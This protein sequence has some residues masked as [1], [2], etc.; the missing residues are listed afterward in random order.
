MD[1]PG[2]PR[3]IPIAGCALDLAMIGR[4]PRE[5]SIHFEIPSAVKLGDRLLWVWTAVPLA[6]LALPSVKNAH[7]AISAQV[8]WSIWAGL[9][10]SGI[11]EWLRR[12]GW[13][14]SRLRA[15]AWTGFVSIALVY[16]TCLWL[17]APRFHRRGVEWGF[18]DSI[19]RTLP[20]TTSL[21]LLYDD[22]DRLPYQC[23]FGAVPHDLAVRLFYL[24]RPACWHQSA[25]SLRDC[26]NITWRNAKPVPQSADAVRGQSRDPSEFVV[27]GRARDL[28]VLERLGQV[29]TIARGPSVRDDRTYLVF[30]ISPKSDAALASGR[31]R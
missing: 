11:G 13:N 7:Y 3:L 12:R 19:G 23:P 18:Y 21:T 29:E 8:P 20:S 15:V 5:Q 30:R 16:G 4:S 28:P 6:L 24:R 10:L 27:V 9:A 22:W 1:T 17:I 26:C 14:R 25:A 2:P 31:E